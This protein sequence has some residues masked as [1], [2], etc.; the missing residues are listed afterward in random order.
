[1]KSREDVFTQS[2]KFKTRRNSVTKE[3]PKMSSSKRAIKT[4]DNL[5]FNKISF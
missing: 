5:F 2:R 1:M 3:T 4:D